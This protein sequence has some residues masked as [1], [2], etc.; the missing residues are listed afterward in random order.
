MHTENLPTI[1]LP[2]GTQLCSRTNI[3][4]SDALQ[5]LNVEKGLSCLHLHHV[6]A[7]REHG[8]IAAVPIW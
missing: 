4:T 6:C 5:P 1:Q 3:S 2:D 8:R 7:A